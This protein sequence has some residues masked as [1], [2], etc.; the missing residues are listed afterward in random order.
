[1]FLNFSFVVEMS[2]QVQEI[3]VLKMSAP[4]DVFD[5]FITPPGGKPKQGKKTK[6]GALGRKA[7]R[8]LTF[9]AHQKFAISRKW[10]ETPSGIKCKNT[11][12]GSR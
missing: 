7:P 6:L 5:G 9:W 4:K 8:L 3:H 10:L 2:K 12:E 11:E 1:M